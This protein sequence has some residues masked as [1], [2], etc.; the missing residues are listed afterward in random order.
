MSSFYNKS[1]LAAKHFPS[2]KIFLS[3]FKAMLSDDS[4]KKEFG[5]YA[6]KC[7]T[8]KQLQIIQREMGIDIY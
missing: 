8:P 2:Y 3:Q 4:I 5:S 7:F 6:G 1:S